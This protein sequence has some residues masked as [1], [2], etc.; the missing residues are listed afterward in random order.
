MGEARE[1]DPV[2]AHLR[3]EGLVV[4]PTETV[5]GFG[6]LATPGALAALR[7]LKGRGDERPFLMLIPGADAVPELVWTDAA[8]ELARVFWPG[9]LTLVLAD[10]TGSFPDGVRGSTGGVAVRVSSHPVTRALVERL[11]RPLTSTSANAPGAAPAATATEARAAA[12]AERGADD[13]W[14]LDVGRLAPSEPSTVVDCTAAEPVVLRVG[15]T[16]ISRLRF[17][18]PGIHGER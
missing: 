16:P 2:V 3:A 17:V 7:R 14:V 1:L 18:L 4:H 11:G 8:R 6:G 12:A 13:L 10:P 5:Y 9:A 15:A